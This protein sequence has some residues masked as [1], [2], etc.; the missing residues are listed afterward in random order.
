MV[1]SRDVTGSPVVVVV[2]VV[3]THD[4]RFVLDDRMTYQITW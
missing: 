1:A 3:A 2:V 4:G